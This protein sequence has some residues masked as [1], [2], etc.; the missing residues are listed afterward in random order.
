M[1][2]VTTGYAVAN[3]LT[4][5]GNTIILQVYRLASHG[6]LIMVYFFFGKKFKHRGAISILIV[7]AGILCFFFENVHRPLAR[8]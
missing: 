4:T 1:A 2:G 6:S 5:A 8:R 3:K 7:L